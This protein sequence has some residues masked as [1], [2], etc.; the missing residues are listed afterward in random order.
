MLIR[1][2][3]HFGTKQGT[4][5][6]QLCLFS[7]L[8]W[9]PEPSSLI[10]PYAGFIWWL[11]WVEWTLGRDA[12]IFSYLTRLLIFTLEASITIMTI[13]PGRRGSYFGTRAAALAATKD[14]LRLRAWRAQGGVPH[15]SFCWALSDLGQR[16]HWEFILL[17]LGEKNGVFGGAV[18]LELVAS[19]PI[20]TDLWPQLTGQLFT[21]LTSKQNTSPSVLSSFPINI[22][23]GLPCSFFFFLYLSWGK[24][25]VPQEWPQTETRG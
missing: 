13:I 15:G 25:Y 5:G 8:P 21:C 3:D 10:A 14:P 16:T 12:F 6:S 1:I 22:F 23:V 9:K 24:P 11:S 17:F 19:V 20:N 7:S 18:S 4:G 2:C